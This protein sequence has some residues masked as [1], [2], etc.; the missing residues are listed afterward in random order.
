MLVD[1][2]S[3]TTTSFD[4]IRVLILQPF[5]QG[6][7]GTTDSLTIVAGANSWS[8]AV[9]DLANLEQTYSVSPE[10]NKFSIRAFRVSLRA[11]T[12]GF[13]GGAWLSPESTGGRGSFRGRWISRDGELAGFVKGYFGVN[14]QGDKVYF[15]KWINRDGTFHGFVTGHWE[16]SGMDESTGMSSIPRTFGVFGGEIRDADR[17]VIGAMRGHWRSARGGWDGFF[18][19]VWSVGARP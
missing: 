11:S 4:G 15:G 17:T 16:D 12:R 14:D 3:H 6:N 7:D 10:G 5:E 1:W 8:F 13:V 18:E 2:I 9:N 19:G